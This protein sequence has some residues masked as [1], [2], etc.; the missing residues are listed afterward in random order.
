MACNSRLVMK[1]VLNY[2][3]DGFENVGSIVDVGGG[4]GATV[5]EIVKAHPH[6]KGFNFDL[7]CV[8]ANAPEYPNV[9]HVGGDMFPTIPHAGAIFLKNVL[10][11]WSDEECLRILKN[12]K[13]AVPEKN[14]K[15]I[16]VDVVLHPQ[17]ESP[18]YVEGLKMD[19]RM[20]ATTSGGKER[21]EDEWKMLLKEGGFPQY[22]IINIP[23]VLSI[24]EAC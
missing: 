4:S 6:I 21:T 3:K 22:R 19:L 23:S 14:G 16:I 11:N 12:C 17:S 13:K 9:T 15:V 10:H 24:I 5:A 1:A 8:V 2:Y 20:L 7:P 18:S